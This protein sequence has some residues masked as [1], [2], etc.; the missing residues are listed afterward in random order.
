MSLEVFLGRPFATVLPVLKSLSW[1]SA[2]F[3]R[4]LTVRAALTG[5]VI[6]YWTLS[7]PAPLGFLPFN[8]YRIQQ[9]TLYPGFASP[10]SCRLQG[11][12]RPS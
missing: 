3:Q 1:P 11:F 4:H 7:E 2:H 6:F 5:P 10:G 12:F 9:S 8:T